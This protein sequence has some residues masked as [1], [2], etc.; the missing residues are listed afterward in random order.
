[1]TLNITP[2]FGQ[3]FITAVPTLL[4]TLCSSQDQSAW[5]RGR[6]L[7]EC[8]NLARRLMETPANR[9]TPTIFAQEATQQLQGCTVTTRYDNDK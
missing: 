5:E 3:T 1:M 7:A 9:M 4:T 2:N 6:T 8:Q